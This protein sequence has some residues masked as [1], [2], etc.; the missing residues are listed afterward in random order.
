MCLELYLASNKLRPA[1]AWDETEPRFHIKHET[2]KMPDPFDLVDV[3]RSNP[4]WY[5]GR[6]CQRSELAGSVSP[7]EARTKS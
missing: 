1:I 6:W 4:R 2:E 7:Q 3:A 5:S